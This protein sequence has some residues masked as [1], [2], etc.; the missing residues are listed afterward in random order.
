MKINT[1]EIVGKSKKEAKTWA[2]NKKL[3]INFAPNG[4]DDWIIESVNVS[5][6]EEGATIT[7]KLKE[8]QK[9]PTNTNDGDNKENE[10]VETLKPPV[11]PGGEANKSKPKK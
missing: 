3:T 11:N 10:S 7:A 6:A 4:E 8:P 9:I 2:A 1:N 5:E